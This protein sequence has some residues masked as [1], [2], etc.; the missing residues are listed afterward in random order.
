MLFRSC[1]SE[2]V[3]F[4][5]CRPEIGVH[6]IAQ[7]IVPLPIDVTIDQEEGCP[8]EALLRLGRYDM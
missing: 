7:Q 5:L 1:R 6:L 3:E 4:R 8:L 2:A